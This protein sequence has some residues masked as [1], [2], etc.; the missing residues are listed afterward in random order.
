M[1]TAVKER[2]VGAVILVGLIVA[3]VPE[4][5]SGPRRPPAAERDA[6]NGTVR[7][8][9]ID[10][11]PPT[12]AEPPE[13]ART[14]VVEP[15]AE[16]APLATPESPDDSPPRV[17]GT[18]APAARPT[19]APASAPSATPT[20]PANSGIDSAW[21]VQLGSFASQENAERLAADVR[22]GGY[23]AFVSRFESGSRVRYRVR[24]GP[25]QDRAQAD[26]LARRLERDGRQVSVVAHP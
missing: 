14:E 11:A 26:A 5:L 19:E 2:L 8:H 6:P 15:T 3:L 12:P 20:R 24:V 23:R 17:A 16:A 1:E 10:L 7:V 25:E 13:T 4:M 9:T 18:N 22:K 21:A